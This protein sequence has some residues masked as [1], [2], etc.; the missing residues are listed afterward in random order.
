[1]KSGVEL[2]AAERERQIQIEGWTAGH[3]DKHTNGELSRA[4]A[5]YCLRGRDPASIGPPM[6][7]PFAEDYWKPGGRIR[8]L[9]KAGALIAAEIDRL[10]RSGISE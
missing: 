2:I 6:F 7:W 5:A 4:A 1:M 3:D 8:S 9:V 10:K